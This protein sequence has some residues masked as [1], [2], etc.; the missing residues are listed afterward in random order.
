MPFTA[1]A[2]VLL[3]LCRNNL[4]PHLA[5]TAGTVIVSNFI[6]KYRKTSL[7]EKG[8]DTLFVK[9]A[10]SALSTHL[11]PIAILKGRIY[12]AAVLKRDVYLMHYSG[13]FPH[14]H[15][16]ERCLLPTSEEAKEAPEA[17]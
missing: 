2:N 6:G 16:K 1:N 8:H 17:R 15:V 3:H 9:I 11:C 5:L 12:D 13:K 14:W 10:K 4:N 7:F